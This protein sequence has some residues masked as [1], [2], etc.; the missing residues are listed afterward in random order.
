MNIFEEV[1]S[2]TNLKDVISFYGIEVKHNMFCCPFHNEKHPSASIKHDYFKCFAC[3]VSG[4]AISFV[5]KYFGL[6]SL[7]ACKK[8][9]ED[10]NLPISLKASSNPIERMR[11]KE[12]ARKRQIELTKRK[13]LERERKQAIYILADY[14]RQL[15]QLSFNNLEADS[16][17]IIQAE[18]K[19]VASILDDLENLKDD[20]ELD[21]YLDV[22]KEEIGKKVIEW[23]N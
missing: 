10:F 5:S 19:R 22:I 13:R 2:Q 6:S 21:N 7:D 15:H 17:A 1:K 16:Q 12:E 4:D 3:G 8:L 23:C 9:I 20:N 18:M 14:H 11:V